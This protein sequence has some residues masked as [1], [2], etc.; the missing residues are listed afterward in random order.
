MITL[1]TGGS[2]SGK[3][4]FAEKLAMGLGEK[5]YYIATMFAKDAES[6]RKVEKHRNMR[7]GKQFQ[8][9]EAERNLAIVNVDGGTM[10]L[11]CMSNLV[12]NEVFGD[13]GGT[14]NA[15]KSIINGINI[16]IQ[17]AENLV[18]VSNEIFSDGITYDQEA[19]K[20]IALLSKVNDYLARLADEVIEVVYGIPIYH[21]RNEEKECCPLY[22]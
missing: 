5:R 20:Y 3:S 14:E 16:L 2:G 22:L 13:D 11:E 19:V 17:K 18:V 7:S 6:L 12:A 4:E 21:K 9:I 15:Y 1:I 8:T 10:L